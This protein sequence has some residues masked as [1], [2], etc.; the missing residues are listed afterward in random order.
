[1]VPRPPLATEYTR[2][3]PTGRSGSGGRSRP[4]AQLLRDQYQRPAAEALPALRRLAAD[5]EALEKQPAASLMTLALLLKE[6]GDQ[7]DATSVLRRHPTIPQSFLALAR[8]GK[9]EQ[10]SRG[11]S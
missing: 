9:L 5:A 6:A 2:L 10:C 1:M 7:S 8:T 11:E 4:L 3:A